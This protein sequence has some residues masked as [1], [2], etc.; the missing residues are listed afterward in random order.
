MVFISKKKLASLTR[1]GAKSR[2][3]L[4]GGRSNIPN[5]LIGGAAVSIGNLLF[6]KY[7]SPRAPALA[8]YSLGLTMLGL[9]NLP[10]QKK[11]LDTG[12]AVT[13]ASLMNRYVIPTIAGHLGG[14]G[15]GNGNGATMQLSAI[16][17]NV[18]T[19]GGS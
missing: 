5:I 19:Q 16:S 15:S 6:N 8:P 7:V 1:G 13:A 10:G 18:L 3:G 14:N 4:L 17:S 12:L 9:S 2:K 11:F